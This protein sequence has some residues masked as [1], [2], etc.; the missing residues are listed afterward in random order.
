MT[1]VVTRS[2]RA[3]RART[4][5]HGT[6]L[7]A[8]LAALVVAT[9][10]ATAAAALG[11]TLQADARGA[12]AV[13]RARTSAEGALA[14][15]LASWPGPWTTT[16]TPGS[17]DARVVSSSAGTA[18]VRALRLDPRRYLLT[19]E[20][21]SAALAGPVGPAV[22]R[23]GVFAQLENVA[24]EAPTALVAAGPVTLGVDTE[25]RAADAA[26]PGWTDCVAT[27]DVSNTAA[28]A[29]PSLRLSTTSRVLG[30]VLTAASAW[31][32][33]IP[34]RFGDV[35]RGALAARADIVLSAGGLITPIPRAAPGTEP[36][37]VRDRTSWGEPF[38]GLSAVAACTSDYPVIYLRGTGSTTL[39]GPARFQG[40]LLVDGSL[41]LIGR[42][43]VAGLV[44][45]G[46]TLRGS[47][48]ALVVDGAL[49]VRGDGASLGTGSRVRRSRCALDRAA[50]A[51]SR[52]VPMTRRAW[53]DVVR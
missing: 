13:L 7:V 49:L 25:V 19:A 43:D 52:P 36:A 46:G 38:R 5:R 51:A 6:A 3:D 45:I 22:R 14:A 24:Y 1:H 42:V 44:V 16:L 12:A 8:V 4:D 10:A 28:V 29:A 40:T 27:P 31:S 21:A 32:A 9:L 35:D 15:V 17:S 39:R 41:D 37:C 23:V 20:A 11:R 48:G 26:P 2:S 34:E 30:P 33:P 50:A 18:T 53:V 47:T